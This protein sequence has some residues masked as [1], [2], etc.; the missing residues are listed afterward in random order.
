MDMRRASVP[1]PAELLAAAGQVAAEQGTSR[2][3][4]LSDWLQSGFRA[5]RQ[6]ALTA[7]YDDFYGEGDPE[8]VPGEIRRARAARFDSRWD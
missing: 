2:A 6:D 1:V 7:A 5:V 3:R 8:P 4:V